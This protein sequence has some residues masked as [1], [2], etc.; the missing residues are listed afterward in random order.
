MQVS[1][2]DYSELSKREQEQAKKKAESCGYDKSQ[3]PLLAFNIWEDRVQG[4]V[5]KEGQYFKEKIYR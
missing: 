1:W 2:K 5:H 3:Y 4:V